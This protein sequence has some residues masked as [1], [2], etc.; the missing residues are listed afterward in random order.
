MIFF[1][2]IFLVFGSNFILHFTNFISHWLASQSDTRFS[3]R[4]D[5][6]MLCITIYVPV[7]AVG[8]MHQIKKLCE[9][10]AIDLTMKKDSGSAAATATASAAVSPAYS[11]GGDGGGHSKTRAGPSMESPA[12]GGGHNLKDSPLLLHDAAS[13]GF[14]ADMDRTDSTSPASRL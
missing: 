5:V 14:L 4:K 1:Y 2:V 9:P 13:A 12:G 11:S 6:K 7:A 3:R 8:V 10:E